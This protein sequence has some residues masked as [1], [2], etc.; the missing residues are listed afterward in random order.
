MGMSRGQYI[1]LERGERR[2]HQH[3]LDRAVKAF[4]K[5]RDEVL[6]DEEPA[7]DGPD[8]S[9]QPMGGGIPEIDIRA[10]MGG[11]GYSSGEVR[12]DGDQSDPYKSETWRFPSTFMRQEVRVPESRVIVIETTGDS[13]APTLHAGDRVIVDTSH[14]IPTPDGI[15]ALR[16]Q[17][18]GIV[19]KRLQVLRGDPP[20]IRII[21]DNANHS[22]EDVGPD[23]VGMVG[24]VLFCLKRL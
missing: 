18:G 22:P 4:G 21:S 2:L 11:G 8:D 15:Y 1:K 10:G 19:V 16:D 5:S 6:G 7:E 23:E 17:F 13:M 9:P 12:H 24:K 20:R 14:V 3:T